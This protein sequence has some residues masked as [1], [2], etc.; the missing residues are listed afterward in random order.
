MASPTEEQPCAQLQP[1]DRALATLEM[2]CV[3]HMHSE[4]L[5]S[6]LLTSLRLDSIGAGGTAAGDKEAAG[7]TKGQPTQRLDVRVLPGNSPAEAALDV[8]Y[9]EGAVVVRSRPQCAL[10]CEAAAAA[11]PSD[12]HN[13][14]SAFLIG[15]L[16][17]EQSKALLADP[18]IM[19][20]CDAVLCSQ[21]LRMNA[22]ELA[23]KVVVGPGNF[24]ANQ[25][26][27]QLPW[28]MDYVQTGQAQPMEPS[29]PIP[30]I[31]SLAALD[32]HV[33]V[34]W[35]LADTVDDDLTGWAN[36]H[37]KSSTVRLNTVGDVLIAVGSGPTRWSAPDGQA[38]SLLTVGYQ[39]GVLAPA[40]NFY[41]THDPGVVATY[42]V[43]LQ[44]LLG[45]HMPG[46]VLNKYYAGPGPH[47]VLGG[48]AVL[49]GRRVDW[50]D[51][52]QSPPPGT[53]EKATFLPAEPVPPLSLPD[54]APSIDAATK[55]CQDLYNN[56]WGK[57]RSQLLADTPAATDFPVTVVADGMSA[58][59]MTARMLAAI[60]RDGV[61]VLANAVPGVVCDT[62]MAE[63]RRYTYMMN[64]TIGSV[65]CVLSRSP[66]AA[67]QMA[68]HP[69]VLGVVEGVLGRQLLHSREGTKQFPWRVHVNETIPKGAGPAQQ[70]HRDGDLNLLNFNN[71]LEHAIGAIWAVVSN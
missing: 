39:L 22:D 11:L 20:V 54:L 30:A 40:E 38:H 62:V 45:F 14:H 44:R 63:L 55:D 23:R 53:P 17:L 46:P 50:F 18:L 8:L 41:L 37:G 56:Y 5:F 32:T 52:G 60:D 25:P 2:W 29:N 12:K 35:Q 16:G 19:E 9:S 36:G 3:E 42:P 69:A 51:A 59:D 31:P 43:E 47:D 15:A 21:A 65:G 7:K 34:V 33:T 13:M 58:A 4:T 48:H 57:L 49:A 6:L 71:E 10:L 61:V 28:E 26:I 27:L 70:L 66:T 64:G 1:A 24:T 68:A 67:H